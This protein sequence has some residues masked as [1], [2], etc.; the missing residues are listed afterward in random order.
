M[1]TLALKDRIAIQDL[2]AQYALACDTHRP[3]DIVD[4]FTKDG[5]FDETRL[6]I[7]QVVRGSMEIREYYHK[8]NEPIA[9][10]THYTTNHII[11]PTAAN[12]AKGTC[13]VYCEI[14][15]RDGSRTQLHAYYDDAY[16]KIRGRWRFKSRVVIPLLPPDLGA[17]LA[18]ASST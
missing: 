7:P 17:Y 5:T 15:L 11:R 10:I 9:H 12:R 6:G 4:L 8:A 16:A 1:A 3:D 2:T 18:V 14:V 13:H